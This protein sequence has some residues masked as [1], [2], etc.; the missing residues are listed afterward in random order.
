MRPLIDS[1]LDSQIFSSA[2]IISAGIAVLFLVSILVDPVVEGFSTAMITRLPRML[3]QSCLSASRTS[4][5][6]SPI[7]AKFH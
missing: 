3:T 4:N 2:N 7:P 1:H 5:L 6:L